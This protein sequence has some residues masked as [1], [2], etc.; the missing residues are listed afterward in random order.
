MNQ[1]ISSNSPLSLKPV[2]CAHLLVFTLHWSSGLVE[3]SPS[4]PTSLIIGAFQHWSH[5]EFTDCVEQSSG[6]TIILLR[7]PPFHVKKTKNKG[8]VISLTIKFDPL[9][10]QMPDKR[11][12]RLP[13]ASRSHN[14]HI[15][16]L[17]WSWVGMREPDGIS[18]VD[19]VCVGIR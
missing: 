15:I 12:C 2:S 5:D 1:F 4:S 6:E 17:H 14:F 10:A 7:S 8:R 18:D 16:K 19:P 11:I 13:V 3:L 9:Y